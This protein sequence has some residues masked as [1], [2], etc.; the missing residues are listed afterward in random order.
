MAL[1]S[2]GFQLVN[3]SLYLSFLV[4]SLAIFLIPGPSFAY[5]IAVG[6]RATIKD[7]IANALGMGIGGLLITVCLAYG[8]A[9]LIS[10]SPFLYRSLQLFGCGYLVF[11]GI[12]TFF[13]KMDQLENVG[14]SSENSVFWKTIL[15]G[16][17]VEVTNPKTMLFYIA[18]VPQFIDLKLGHVDQQLMVLGSTF[19]LMGIAWD[20]LLMLTVYRIR[21]KFT[22]AISPHQRQVINRISGLTFVGLG[23]T[24][25]LQER[26]S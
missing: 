18:F 25:L 8:A 17:L 26:S 21:R 12:K 1:P 2:E 14:N 22:L 13:S 19:V 15:Q 5:S 20:I 24:L 11:L 4:T 10:T 3:T 7:I 6:I 9:Q 16:L 23:I